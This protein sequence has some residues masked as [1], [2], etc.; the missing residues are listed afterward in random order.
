M[1]QIKG[2]Q[3]HLRQMVERN[4][5]IERDVQRYKERKKIEHEVRF[6]VFDVIS[7]SIPIRRS[8]F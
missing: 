6:V 1:Q 4:E 3:E 2:E 5:G 8:L 7:S